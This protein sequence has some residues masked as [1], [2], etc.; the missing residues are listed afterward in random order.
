MYHIITMIMTC[1]PNNITE[2]A[3]PFILIR[4]KELLPEGE[5]TSLRSRHWCRVRSA[6]A[7]LKP[8]E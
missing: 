1:Y 4:Q 3:L 6:N 7:S 8:I 5:R 2:L